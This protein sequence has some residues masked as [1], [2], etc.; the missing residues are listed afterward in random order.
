VGENN[1]LAYF[2]LTTAIECLSN[3]YG[4]GKG[5]CARFIDFI[6]CYYPDSKQLGDEIDLKVLLKEIYY[7]H[8]S[9]FTHGGKAI[10]DAALLADRLSRVY[11]CNVVD[12]K[13]IR[14]PGLNWFEKVV[15]SSIV[16]F[17]L[18]QPSRITEEKDQFKNISLE[19]GKVMLKAAR[20]LS[21]HQIVS[22]SDFRLD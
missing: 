21:A 22:G 9:G 3:R 4:K 8:R 15:R 16:A 2:L 13:E 19:T 10:P 20:N 1:T 14:T 5:Y 18:A 7:R 11:V 6:L 17:M 12:G